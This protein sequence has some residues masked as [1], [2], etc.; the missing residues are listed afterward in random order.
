MLDELLYQKTIGKKMARLINNRKNNLL[1]YIL[2]I[3][4]LNFNFVIMFFLGVFSLIFEPP[5][6]ILDWHKENQELN[7]SLVTD[8]SVSGII[9]WLFCFKLNYVSRLNFNLLYFLW[10]LCHLIAIA[11]FLYFLIILGIRSDG[12]FSGLALG[13]FFGLIIYSPFSILYSLLYSR[14]K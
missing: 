1:Q 14:L 8:V 10:L 3:I 12:T 7:Y 5:R 11:T 9:C 2:S 6:T 13:V 4:S